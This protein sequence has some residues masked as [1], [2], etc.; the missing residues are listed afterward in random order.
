M[1]LTV[2]P[3]LCPAENCVEQGFIVGEG[4]CRGVVQ[5]GEFAVE[6]AGSVVVHHRGGVGVVV[7]AEVDAGAVDPQAG[8]PV[9]TVSGDPFVAG[10][11]VPVQA[12]VGLILALGAQA[13]IGARVV[14]AV[15]VDVIDVLPA[16]C[17]QNDSVHAVHH[18]LAVDT[19]GAD[20]IAFAVE[21]PA[22]LREIGVVC[23]V[24]KRE[25]ALG[26]GNQ[27]CHARVTFGRYADE[28]EWIS[29]RFGTANQERKT[30]PYYTA[31]LPWKI[32]TSHTSKGEAGDK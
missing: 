17:A 15:V 2:I 24:D 12:S 22:P 23:I 19:F 3:G 16:P 28:G 31:N 7:V 32:T 1:S 27:L 5:L 14:E 21:P 29:E 30:Y 8:V 10:G 11:G 4:R 18:V 9:V 6:A 20:G 25:L 26:E 13:E